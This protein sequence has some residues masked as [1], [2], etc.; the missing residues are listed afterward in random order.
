MNIS[1]KILSL[2]KAHNL[3]QEQLA[4]QINVSRQSVSKWESGQ[5]VPEIDKLTALSQ[6]FHV[7]TD[8]LLKPS[9]VDEL[10]LKAEM[11]ERQ[12][13]ELI[14]DCQKKKAAQ[15]ILLSCAGIYLVAFAVIM[16][17]HQLS[18]EVAFL[19]NIFPWVSLH[20]M[21]LLIATALAVFVNLKH[22]KTYFTKE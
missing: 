6:V 21:V 11:L 1:E 4:E 5:A 2:R 18:W 14:N 16:F 19:W 10:T 3:T 13:Q 22:K 17:L 7:T 8:Y 15:F 9:E 20:I 12:Q